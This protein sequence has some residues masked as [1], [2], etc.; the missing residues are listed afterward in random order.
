MAFI[1][2]VA[3]GS[4]AHGRNT[5]VVGVGLVPPPPPFVQI[6]R[7]SPL[8]GDDLLGRWRGTW[9]YDRGPCVIDIDRVNGHT[10]TGTLTKG[11]TKVTF[12]GIFDPYRRTIQ[13]QETKILS[14]EYRSWSLGTNSGAFSAD[15]RTLMG[16]G[17]DRYGTYGWDLEK[18]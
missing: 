6:D 11:G 16:T 3:A 9:D 15:G 2:G 17:T 10:F 12:S 7:N 8:R 14:D 13:F 18:E 4:L 5:N 1:T